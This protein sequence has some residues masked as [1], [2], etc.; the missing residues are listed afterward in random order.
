MK[1]NKDIII[2]IDGHASCGKSTLAKQLASA[3]NYTYIDTGAMYRAVT[4][5]ALRR[6]LITDHVLT[7][8]LVNELDKIHIEFRYNAQL[9]KAETYLNGENVEDEIRGMEVS[10][11]VSPI[12]E[13]AQVRSHLV[14]LQQ[15]MGKNKRIVM[16]GRDIGTVV[17]PEA[18]LKIFLTASAHER[19][20]RRYLELK[21]KG[22]DIDFDEI[23]KNV[24]ERDRIDSS[25]D[26]SPLK[27]AD[28]A[29]IIDNTNLGIEEQFALVIAI[30]AVRFGKGIDCLL[31]D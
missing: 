27:P 24:Q 10:Q 14:R 26:V 20:R 23:L 29:I 13:I 5:Y 3:L 30:L 11:W 7:Q 19:A 12:A 15:A 8:E 21:E 17:F 6:G 18:E 1:L 9:Q 22:Q 2:A 16:D 4:L 28:D 25:R 31:N